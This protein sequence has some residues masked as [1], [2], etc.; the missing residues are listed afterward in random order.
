MTADAGEWRLC[1]AAEYTDA[2]DGLGD[3]AVVFASDVVEGDRTADGSF[4][5]RS[6]H[7][8]WGRKGDAT[9]L[10]RCH[11]DWNHAGASTH[12]DWLFIRNDEVQ[13]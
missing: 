13:P 4:R 2:I 1:S 9:P 10:A 11:R 7:T 5:D 3:E 6:V 12:Q 8:D